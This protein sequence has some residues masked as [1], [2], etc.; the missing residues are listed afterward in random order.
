MS[1]PSSWSRLRACIPGHCIESISL[2]FR[3]RLHFMH[4]GLSTFFHFSQSFTSFCPPLS[5]F[6]I[7]QL[8]G[9]LCQACSFSPETTIFK[10]LVISC[11]IDGEGIWGNQFSVAAAAAAAVILLLFSLGLSRRFVWH[12]L[13]LHVSLARLVFGASYTQPEMV[14]RKSKTK[15]WTCC[16]WLLSSLPSL[17]SAKENNSLETP[18]SCW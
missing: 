5:K 6:H 3:R 8:Q 18:Q 12:C 7:K 16:V 2:P 17:C 4:F 14:L 13:F 10:K 15:L 11:C 1:F 9:H